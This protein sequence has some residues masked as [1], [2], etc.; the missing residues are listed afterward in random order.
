[1]KAYGGIVCT[2]PL[3]LILR[4]RGKGMVSFALQSAFL[5]FVVLYG[6]ET[7]SLILSKEPGLRVHIVKCVRG[8]CEHWA[9]HIKS[10]GTTMNGLKLISG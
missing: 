10:Q 8:W 6:C 9:H 2:A 3:F 7:W 1:M 5:R 4:S